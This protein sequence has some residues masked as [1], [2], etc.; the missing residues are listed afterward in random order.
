MTRADREPLPVAVVLLTHK[1]YATRY[2][3]ECIA[4]LDRQ[5]YPVADFNVF[6]VTNGVTEDERRLVGRL[7]P[8]ARILHQAQNLGWGGGCNAAIRA[9][10]AEGCRCV[11]LL[12]I[13]TLVEPD[14]LL[15]LVEAAEADAGLHILQSKILL[16]GTGRINSVGNR[17]QFL[18]YGY[19]NGYG[20]LDAPDLPAFPI[21]AVSGA[22]ML[23][24]R[25]VFERIGFFRDDYLI[26]Y[27]DT[28][29]CWRARLAGFDVGVAPRSICHHKYEFASRLPM[30][31]QLQRN[32]LLT[33]LTL[34][35]LR[36]LLLIAPCLLVGELLV[37]GYFIAQGRGGVVLALLR[38]FARGR[39]WRQI[40]AWRREVR[41]LRRRRDDEIVA[42]FAADIVFAE[43]DGPAVR[44]LINPALRLYWALIRPLIRW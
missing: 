16:N 34:P 19:C 31:Y 23:I 37:G 24:K 17:I 28:E 36:S 44:Y 11:V 40:A 35:R 7:A 32:R 18:G 10:L 5:T 22:A 4:G 33:F 42:H 27:D 14:W 13:D 38:Y 41:A 1:D 39:T 43:V 8:K 20:W 9:A 12:N 2:L 30:L 21:D 6:I 15:R 3:A 25:E 29:F 26:Y